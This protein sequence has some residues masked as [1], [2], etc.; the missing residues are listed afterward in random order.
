[1]DRQRTRSRVQSF[2]SPFGVSQFGSACPNGLCPV[3]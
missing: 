2:G 1:V 3:R